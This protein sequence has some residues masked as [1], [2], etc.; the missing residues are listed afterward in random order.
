MRTL[1]IAILLSLAP[2]TASA[3]ISERDLLEPGDGLLTYDD[4]NQREWLDLTVDPAL[5]LGRTSN[6][7]LPGWQCCTIF[8]LATLAE[9]SN[10]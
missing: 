6:S 2:L 10:R 4:V 1:L 5:Q 7:Y 3:T 9:I 8:N